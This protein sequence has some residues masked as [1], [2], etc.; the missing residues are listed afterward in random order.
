MF[1]LMGKGAIDDDRYFNKEQFGGWL[2]WSLD[3]HKGEGK[4]R[5]ERSSN[6]T[7]DEGCVPTFV[8]WL[9]KMWFALWTTIIDQLQK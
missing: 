1:P 8:F 6:T 9:I 3:K 5:E 7:F 4:I 2:N